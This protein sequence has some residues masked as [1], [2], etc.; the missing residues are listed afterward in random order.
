MCSN[1]TCILLSINFNLCCI[2]VSSSSWKPPKTSAQTCTSIAIPSKALETALNYFELQTRH[3]TFPKAGSSKAVA[4]PMVPR[5][6]KQPNVPAARLLVA[7][8][9]SE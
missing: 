7:T 1:D 8:S 9:F 3:P 4:V 6:G 5:G 2:T